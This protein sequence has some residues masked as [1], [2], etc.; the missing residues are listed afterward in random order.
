MTLIKNGIVELT[1][2]NEL[3][4]LEEGTALVTCR[5]WHYYLLRKTAPEVNELFVLRRIDD[6][7]VEALVG[8]VLLK[9]M[10]DTR[11]GRSIFSCDGERHQYY[12]IEEA[13]HSLDTALRRK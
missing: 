13:F 1:D 7:A 8:N 10:G 4:E 9:Q 2:F 12:D 3:I 5:E 6:S 11:N